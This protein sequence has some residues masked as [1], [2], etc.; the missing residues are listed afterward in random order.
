[1]TVV[2]VADWLTCWMVVPNELSV[3]SVEL[4]KFAVTRWEPTARVE[5]VTLAVPESGPVGLSGTGP[6]V[7]PPAM[8][9]VTSPHGGAPR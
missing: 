6:R 3:A 1:M 4:T 2:V 9:K 5:S 8:A 7:G